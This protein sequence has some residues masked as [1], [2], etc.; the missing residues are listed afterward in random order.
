MACWDL[1]VR[2]CHRRQMNSLPPGRSRLELNLLP[3]T[4]NP[5][6]L[7]LVEG[8]FIAAAIV[9]LR[10]PRGRMVCHSGGLFERAAV[11]EIGRDP[12]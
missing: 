12:G 5:Y 2:K 7:N 11:L 6:P 8:E 9:E 10:R 3:K 1:P 4:S